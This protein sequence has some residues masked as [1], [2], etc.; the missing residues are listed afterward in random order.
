[1]SRSVDDEVQTALRAAGNCQQLVPDRSIVFDR[2]RSRS[3]VAGGHPFDSWYHN[4][5]RQSLIEDEHLGRAPC[6]VSP[7]AGVF[8]TIGERDTERGIRAAMPA[9]PS[10]FTAGE[11]NRVER[12]VGKPLGWRRR[13]DC[14]LDAHE[15]PIVYTV[16]FK[17]PVDSQPEF[18][19]WYGEEHIPLLLGCPQWVMS[20]RFDVGAVGGDGW[21]RLTL[22]YLTNVSA[23][24]SPERALGRRTPWRDRLVKQSW[25][26]GENIVHY[27]AP[28]MM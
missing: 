15:A 22:H 9:Q 19:R 27:R 5:Y 14:T 18:D 11:E 1:M 12:M 21:T 24:E 23:L 20:R 28:A 6:Y 16:L 13:I 10:A 8:L 3:S 2:V 26:P 4:R 7:T 17:V 25:F